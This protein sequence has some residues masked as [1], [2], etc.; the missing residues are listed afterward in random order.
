MKIDVIR[1]KFANSFTRG[2]LFIN[3]E[4]FCDTLEDTDRR[5]EKTDNLATIKA[6]KVQGK[7]AIPAGDYKLILTPSNRFKRDL[8][9]ILDV[10]AFEGVR[11]HS[12]NT[13]EDTE[14][15]ILVGKYNN[16]GMVLQSRDT[17][18][19]LFAEICKALEAGEEIS[20]KIVH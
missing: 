10:P 17:F 7:T 2:R 14:G 1:E 4:Y 15:C 12:G 5:L 16:K 19:R 20:L 6:R 13:A 9:L 8:P 3:G 11:I 18:A